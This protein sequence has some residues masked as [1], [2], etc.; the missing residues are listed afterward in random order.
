MREAVIAA[1]LRIAIEVVTEA[2]R[3]LLRL[4]GWKIVI[5]LG[6]TLLGARSTMLCLYCIEGWDASNTFPHLQFG[7][8][9]IVESSAKD[10]GIR[11]DDV[12]EVGL[13][14]AHFAERLKLW[15]EIILHVAADLEAL[16]A[17]AS[18]NPQDFTRYSDKART[19]VLA[20]EEEEKRHPRKQ[21]RNITAALAELMA[22]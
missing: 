7:K 6:A 16:K 13:R 10:A 15:G 3:M 9:G 21:G 14:E 11:Q 2:R 19:A 5:T 12:D 22:Q 17:S 4:G 1:R 8:D 18:D 20:M